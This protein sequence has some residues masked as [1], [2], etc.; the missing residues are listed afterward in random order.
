MSDT[1]TPIHTIQ[2]HNFGLLYDRSRTLLWQWAEQ[3]AFDQDDWSKRLK[4]LLRGLKV[5]VM[6]V[7]IS[8]RKQEQLGVPIHAHPDALE[9]AF[10]V[11]L[12]TCVS[13]PQAWRES[14]NWSV[15]AMTAQA[16]SSALHEKLPIAGTEAF[17]QR[18]AYRAGFALG[19]IRR[20]PMGYWEGP[21]FLE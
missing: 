18:M 14:V 10:L 5:G 3:D 4:R 2:I 16:I 17:R 9:P 13:S 7:V 12:I 6:R 11:A 8:D 20:R 15:Y 19:K 21:I 1:K